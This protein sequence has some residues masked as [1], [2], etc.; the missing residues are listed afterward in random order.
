MSITDKD[1]DKSVRLILS[2]WVCMLD[3]RPSKKLNSVVVI[4]LI[5]PVKTISFVLKI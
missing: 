4:L 5:E 3:L 2:I 1:P